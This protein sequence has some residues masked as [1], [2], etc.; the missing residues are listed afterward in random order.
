MRRDHITSQPF[1]FEKGAFLPHGRTVYDNPEHIPYGKGSFQG[2]LI[3]GLT[4]ADGSTL[5][6]AKD[7][8]NLVKKLRMEQIGD[9][10]ASIVHQLG[11]YKH[12][13]SGEIV[14]EE[15]V[16]VYILHLTDETRDQFQKNIMHLADRLVLALH[17]NEVIVEFSNRGLVKHVFGVK[18]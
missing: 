9:P 18:P 16:R 1:V 5:Y 7:V 6:D 2:S 3:V 17:Q 12:R 4:S 13:E 14:T 15:S 10:G 8:V 11:L